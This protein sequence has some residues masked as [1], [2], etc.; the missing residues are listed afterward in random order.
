[1]QRNRMQF[2]IPLPSRVALLDGS[3]V[4]WCHYVISSNNGVFYFRGRLLEHAVLGGLHSAI[5][6]ERD[7]NAVKES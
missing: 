1:M 2:M 4:R 3:L 5:C 7:R 6:A